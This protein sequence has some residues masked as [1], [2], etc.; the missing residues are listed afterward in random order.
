[1]RQK[2]LRNNI[3]KLLEDKQCL[4]ETE[5]YKELSIND[6]PEEKLCI[7]QVATSLTYEGKI[8]WTT[9]DLVGTLSWPRSLH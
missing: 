7:S 2:E 8:I 1:M 9:G 4:T 5:L 3:L 6:T